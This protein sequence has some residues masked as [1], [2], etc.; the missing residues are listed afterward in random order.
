MNKR[1]KKNDDM[2]TWSLQEVLEARG[3]TDKEITL[4]T[5]HAE[6]RCRVYL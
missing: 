3:Y 5:A 6:D 1:L 2:I 4:F